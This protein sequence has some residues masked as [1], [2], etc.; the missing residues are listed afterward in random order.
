MSI[1]T[2]LQATFADK[3]DAEL[4]AIAG[5]NRE[6]KDE[7]GRAITGAICEELIARN[8]RVAEAVHDWAADLDDET[9]LIDLL[10]AK[11]A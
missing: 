6:A 2:T 7:A 5:I 9:H 8:P 3:T 10:S 11:L 4:F 1:I